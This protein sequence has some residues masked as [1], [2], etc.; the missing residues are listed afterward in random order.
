MSA[1]TFWWL[2]VGST[3]AAVLIFVV[4]PMLLGKRD[5]GDPDPWGGDDGKE[6]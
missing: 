3:I 5:G 6:E 2:F 4:A 1:E